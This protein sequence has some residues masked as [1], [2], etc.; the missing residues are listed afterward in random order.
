MPTEILK[1]RPF[2]RLLTMLGDQLIKNEQIAL[3]EIIKNSYDANADYVKIDFNN[4][5]I[6]YEITNE[7][8]IIITD[9]G[10]GM[11]K[12]V[13]KNIWM[14]PATP[15]KYASN[16]KPLVVIKGERTRIVQ[17]EK[18]I[19]RFALLKLGKKVEIITRPEDEIATEYV[20]T[21]DLSAYDDE[22]L[23]ENEDA[24]DIYLDD[25]SLNLKK[26]VP[27]KF[28]NAVSKHGTQIIISNLKGAWNEKKVKFVMSEMNKIEPIFRKILTKENASEFDILFLKDG[29]LIFQSD[30]E[31]K[32]T[33]E[34]IKQ[35]SVLKI[36]D[37]QF[38]FNKPNSFGI[39]ESG[40]FTF[41]V[42]NQKKVL[43]TTDP[44]IFGN[45]EFFAKFYDKTKQKTTI[46]HFGDF[47]FG[48]YIFDFNA[49]SGTKFFL[50]RTNKDLIREHRI[51]LYRDGIRVAP[52]GDKKD[53]WLGIDIHRGT[54]SASDFL[55]NDQIIGW[56]EISKEKNPKLKDKTNREGLIE[57]GNFVAAFISMIRTILSIIKNIYFKSILDNEKTKNN[58]DRINSEMISNK[59][60][61]LLAQPEIS[62]NEKEKLKSL[63]NDYKK[64]KEY[65]SKR[66]DT[67]EELAGV[68]LSVEMA[69]HDILMVQQLGIKKIEEL[70][71]SLI[72]HHSNEDEVLSALQTLLGSFNFVTSKLKD[73]QL[74]FGS[75]QRRRPIKVREIVEKIAELYYKPINKQGINLK[76][77]PIGNPIIAKCTDAVL[78]QL[79]IN[80]F[81]NACYWLQFSSELEKKIKIILDGNQQQM[82]FS[83]NGPGV[84]YEDIPYIFE[85]FY[86]LK[87]D[88]GRGLGLYIARTL[89][90]KNDYSIEYIDDKQN[91]ILSG[92]NFVV[93]FFKE[94]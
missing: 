93:N 33:I 38:C 82:F 69:S 41:T 63:Y 85:P 28:T 26:R 46:P 20:L 77:E 22:F 4:F 92:A 24:R 21:F 35:N 90:V 45:K 54:I 71:S 72:N 16:D 60:E 9:N 61:T 88:E 57:E 73:I 78:M 19:G 39:Y 14:S 12:D 64:E 51:Y 67:T 58:F 27:Q 50:E 81:D 86:T 59:F 84:P 48:F 23:S 68:G 8:K 79:C 62:N 74:L 2:A 94:E 25:I 13:I 70:I 32:N 76:I 11:S 42:N 56:I 29:V 80:L 30:T 5:G 65:F 75:R 52:Y 83:D 53:D 34:L 47:K 10:C 17:G 31:F 91:K 7:S 1:F 3:T 15:N 89:L 40:V 55:S 18:G 87:G 36:S 66:L 44:E 43:Q 49:K 37:G 6:N